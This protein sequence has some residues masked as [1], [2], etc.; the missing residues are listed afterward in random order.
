MDFLNAAELRDKLVSLGVDIFAEN[1]RLRV[2]APSG[3]L[4]EEMQKAI[5]ARKAE[6]LEL[7]DYPITKIESRVAE[8][9]KNLL[10]LDSVNRTDDFFELGGHSLLGLRL[11]AM[12]EAE[13]R[14]RISLATLFKAPTI[15]GLALAIERGEESQSDFQKVVRLHVEGTRPQIFAI[16]D[17]GAYYLLAKKLGPSWPLT[18]L[19]L[20]EPS[21]PIERMPER[22]EEVAAHY[23]EL[24]R[25]IQPKGPY[26]LLSWCAGGILTIEIAHQLLAANE[27]VSF[28]ALIEA[29]APVRYERFSWL[30]SKLAM[31]SFRVKWNLAEL[32]KLRTGEQS[33]LKFLT[34]RR[35]LQPAAQRLR[36]FRGLKAEDRAVEFERWLMEKYLTSLAKEYKLKTFP[37]RVHLFRATK[38]PRGL[39]LDELNGWGL[40]AAG[41]VEISFI[42][43]DHDSIFRPPGVDQLAEKISTAL[44]EATE[45]PKKSPKANKFD[46][47]FGGFEPT[48]DLKH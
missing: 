16:N 13:F 22:L 3:T 34:N 25:Q 45:A 23:V 36:S 42:E 26:N 39:F 38:M 9:W 40:Y 37:G 28:L 43:G 15:E 1:G 31:N 41:G 5:S 29:Y 7:L 2:S 10:G 4:T 11:L 35:S 30:R 44:V 33:L 18:A 14:C 47:G 20:Y 32:K 46:V 17:T 8:I 24:I 12:L 27:E 6:L 48:S 21:Y 19:Q